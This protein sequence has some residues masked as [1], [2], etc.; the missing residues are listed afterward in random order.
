MCKLG[1]CTAGAPVVC[2]GGDQCHA[3]GACNRA[4]GACVN[5]PL[6]DGTPCTDGDTCTSGDQCSSGACKSGTAV[7]C[8]ASDGCHPGVCDSRTGA[9]TNVAACQL[10]GVGAIAGTAMDGLAVTP[11]RLEDGTPNNQIGAFG[12]AITYT[13]AAT[14][15]WRR[16][17][18]VRTTA[19]ISF[20]DRYY[21]IDVALADG[22]VT[23]HCARRVR[24]STKGPGSDT[25]IGL[26][27]AFDATNSPASRRLDLRRRARRPARD[28]LRLRRV[29]PV[30]V[31]VRR[32]R[33]PHPR[34]ERA[35]QVPDRSPRASRTP[36]CR[37]PTPW[38]ART[39]AAWKGSRSRPTAASSTASCR[40]R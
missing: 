3:A 40:A 4:S 5:A 16:P 7:V 38:A 15:S 10:Y 26:D 2:G 33:R 28:V 20:T 19:P 18:A 1:A 14:C 25:F 31:R 21:L 39:T 13:G 35:R 9:C 36:S 30:P 24:R 8:A 29:R 6:A 12:S 23:P 11:G 37:P 34:A 32:Q 27:S 22:Q 17:I